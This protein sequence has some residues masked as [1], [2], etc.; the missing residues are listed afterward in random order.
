[1]RPVLIAAFTVAAGVLTACGQGDADSGGNGRVVAPGVEVRG[2]EGDQTITVNSER[3]GEMVIRTGEGAA[4]A[5]PEGPAY[6]RPYP[7]SQVTQSITAPDGARMVVFS[8]TDNPDTI[9]AYYRQQAE[10]AGLVSGAAMTMG[11]TRM[12]GADANDGGSLA[13]M[14][15]P[16]DGQSQV[17][18]T[19]TAQG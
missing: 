19:W 6:V 9:I 12:Y 11:E 1:M 17:T 3:E 13:V 8:S 15:A 5:V 16:S 4:A 7:G 2:P 18:L 14:V 10:Q